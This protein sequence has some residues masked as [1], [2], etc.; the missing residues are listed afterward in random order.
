M[1]CLSC[2][3]T[4]QEK[5]PASTIPVSLSQTLNWLE[6][7]LHCLLMS[8]S[9]W[10]QRSGRTSNYVWLC[11]TGRAT[12]SYPW[13]LSSSSEMWIGSNM[14]AWRTIHKLRI[15]RTRMNPEKENLSGFMF[16]RPRIR[17]PVAS[18]KKY[19]SKC[20][21]NA[22]SFHLHP[23]CTLASDVWYSPEP[24]GVHYLGNMLTYG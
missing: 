24:M 13:H 17:C 4:V 23:K 9:A 14:S 7:P 22:K 21:S 8:P 5:I 11:V 1:W 16:A 2:T 20:P 18:V 3:K 19:I 12:A 15:T 6:I 10:S